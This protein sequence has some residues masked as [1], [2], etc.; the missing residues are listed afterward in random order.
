MRFPPAPQYPTRFP[1]T[2][3][4]DD[5]TTFREVSPNSHRDHDDNHTN[6]DFRSLDEC[7]T[8]AEDL[9]SPPV[10]LA[11]DPVLND[12]DVGGYP[13]VMSTLNP[14]ES[15]PPPD[16]ELRPTGASF[17]Q[18]GHSWEPSNPLLSS[19]QRPQ[20][21]QRLG[22]DNPTSSNPFLTDPPAPC[23]SSGSPSTIAEYVKENS[24]KTLDSAIDLARKAYAL[25]VS[26]CSNDTIALANLGTNEV[27]KLI[28]EVEDKTLRL[29]VRAK[30]KQ[31]QRHSSKAKTRETPSNLSC[32]RCK[33]EGHVWNSCPTRKT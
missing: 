18:A 33:L 21:D 1:A 5:T 2:L 13:D 11:R 30:E 14:P 25:K 10:S 16:D 15:H 24:P 7:R 4:E 20:E 6:V 9:P 3:S 23:L 32:F 17:A 8:A 26:K 19:P 29:S 28:K 12:G 27:D 31:G 22:F